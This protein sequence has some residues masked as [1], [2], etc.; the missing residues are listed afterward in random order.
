MVMGLEEV[1]EG[2]PVEVMEA[3]REVILVEEA[4][5]QLVVPAAVV[6]LVVRRAV[7]C[8]GEREVGR[9][10]VAA[11]SAAT[12][13]VVV[14]QRVGTTVVGWAEEELVAVDRER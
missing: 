14:V 10:L 9:E 7:G 6:R 3:V 11:V 4:S 2:T 13:D 1:L 5:I 12:E 8:L